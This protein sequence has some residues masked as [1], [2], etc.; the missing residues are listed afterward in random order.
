LLN[1]ITDPSAPARASLSIHWFTAPLAPN[2]AI[3][4]IDP[5]QSG[6]RCSSQ[7]PQLGSDRG[8]LLF[9][10]SFNEKTGR[11]QRLECDFPA[12]IVLLMGSA[13]H[14]ISP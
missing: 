12:E 2:R 8:I 5:P 1:G 13:A 3:K 11:F 6:M 4:L 9:Y 7:I 14:R 10:Q